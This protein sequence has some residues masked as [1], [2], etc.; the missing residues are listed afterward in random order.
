M[1]YLSYYIYPLILQKIRILIFAIIILA[2][3]YL[4]NN[5]ITSSLELLILQIALCTFALGMWTGQPILYK[6]LPVFKRFTTSSFVYALSRISV[7]VITSL[8][9]VYL[10]AYFGN[11]GILVVMIPITIGFACGINHFATLEK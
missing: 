7:F 4:L 1:A 3:P 2:F 5:F 9:F 10:T 8:G 6:H 11:Y